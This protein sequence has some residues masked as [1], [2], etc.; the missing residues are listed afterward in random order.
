VL[1]STLL[2][3]VV[4]SAPPPIDERVGRQPVTLV[5]RELGTGDA[6]AGALVWT[7]ATG[8]ITR[9][10]SLGGAVI[11]ARPGALE[12]RAWAPGYERSEWLGLTIAPDRPSG[13]TIR[14]AR[15]VFPIPEVLVEAD[16]PFEGSAPFQEFRSDAAAVRSLPGAFQDPV[17][18]LAVLPGVTAPN[19]LSGLVRVR[20]GTPDQNLYLIDGVRLHNP[21]RLRILYGG[22]LTMFHADVVR[23]V[24]VQG[25]G[26][27]ARYGDRLSSVIEVRTREPDRTRTSVSASASLVSASALVEG[28]LARGRG[29]WLLSARRTSYDLA[30]NRRL[31]GGTTLPRFYDFQ[32]KGVYDLGKTQELVLEGVYGFEET[33][34]RGGDLFAVN[35]D[36]H[37]IGE[38]ESGLGAFIYRL[39]PTT[40]ALVEIRGSAFDDRNRLRVSESG[41]RLANLRTRDFGAS[42]RGE[43][44]V[45]AG[46]NEVL[47]GVEQTA[48]RYRLA[49]SKD[50][51]AATIHIATPEN[52][53]VDGRKSHGGIFG[54][55]KHAFGH[56]ITLSTGLRADETTINGERHL[57]PRLAASWLAARAL[58]VTLAAG[59]FRQAPEPTLV[60]AR[61][62]AYDFG[63]DLDSL[64]SERAT[65]LDAALRWSRDGRHVVRVGAY[66]RDLG[67][68]IV[69][70]DQLF[71][72]ESSGEGR[73]SGVEIMVQRAAAAGS[74][75]DGFVTYSNSRSRVR[76][77]I[78]ESWTR[79]EGHAYHGATV[80]LRAHPHP[81]WTAGALLRYLSGRAYAALTA[82]LPVYANE[83]AV[84]WMPIYEPANAH[85]LPEY[86]RL[87]LRADHRCRILGRAVNLFAEL[88]NATDRANAVGLVWNSNYTESD[89]LTMLPRFF[90]VGFSVGF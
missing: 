11:L 15:R 78:Y 42:F 13:G 72:A 56:R 44:S 43:F 16:R 51:G 27:S 73:A 31:D 62:R 34:V 55:W 19:D 85:E 63:T 88:I 67:N 68:L 9:T 32:A 37:T 20:G 79:Q 2:V 60:F 76:G 21:Y 70:K 18:A 17:R 7:R 77:G 74:L 59:V 28:P 24:R 22:A 12:L 69:P 10:D 30:L 6:I 71:H 35:A 36:A 5:V 58:S 25:G 40:G 57:S 48:G 66:V 81:A 1:A 86:F 33:D 54:E 41:D 38:S 45:R 8:E 47:L 89:V 14:L 84:V 26:F 65:H 87:D 4:A 61:E 52:A 90:S 83:G 75:W 46:G 49:W 29:S 80:A 82:K 3:L 39:I 53:A 23:D 64:E 50:P